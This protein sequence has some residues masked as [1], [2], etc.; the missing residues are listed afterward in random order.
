MKMFLTILGLAV[1]LLAPASAYA[2]ACPT[3]GS[4][5]YETPGSNCQLGSLVTSGPTPVISGIPQVIARSS[6]KAAQDDGV[7]SDYSAGSGLL[8]LSSRGSGSMTSSGPATGNV[9]FFGPQSMVAMSNSTPA[10]L[11]VNGLGVN[12]L[13]V[14]GLAP[15][16]NRPQGPG[17]GTA[18]FPCPTTTPEPAS[19]VL[20]G[21]GLVV[22]GGAAFRRYRRRQNEAI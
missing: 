16:S 1:A 15:L 4:S 2:V 20:L 6:L 17:C 8:D 3:L 21:S 22:L 9:S 19:L 13:G 11:G 10:T 18:A 7:S 14:G 12:G 5:L